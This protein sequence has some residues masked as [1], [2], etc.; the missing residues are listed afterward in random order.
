MRL[1]FGI[2]QF[3]FSRADFPADARHPSA[4][5]LT[6]FNDICPSVRWYTDS[7]SVQVCGRGYDNTAR[8]QLCCRIRR[9]QDCL[10]YPLR[11]DLLLLD[12][13]YEFLVLRFDRLIIL[14]GKGF[15]VH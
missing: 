3:F 5:S 12:L 2:R 10:R 6:S 1:R 13:L 7:R 8:G 9:V 15:L 14:S 11:P 4:V